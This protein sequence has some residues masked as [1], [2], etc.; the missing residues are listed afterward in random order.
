MALHDQ[1]KAWSQGDEGEDLPA[2]AGEGPCNEISEAPQVKFSNPADF[3]KSAQEM[4]RT[5]QETRPTAEPLEQP[6]FDMTPDEIEAER[7]ERE[8]ILREMA[9]KMTHLQALPKNRE[10]QEIAE[11]SEEN[12]DDALK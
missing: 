3:L 5:L 11:E 6:V 8:A 1:I 12:W 2:G 7:A 4:I 10:A 9:G